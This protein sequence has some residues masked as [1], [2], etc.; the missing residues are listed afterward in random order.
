MAQPLPVAVDLL[1]A[2]SLL[3][4]FGTIGLAVRFI[5]ETGPRRHRRMLV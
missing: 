2:K 3:P 1:K 5:A 4:S